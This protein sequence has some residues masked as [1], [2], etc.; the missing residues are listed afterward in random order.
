MSTFLI[1]RD[2]P[3]V[4]AVWSGVASWPVGGRCFEFK[5]YGYNQ[6]LIKLYPKCENDAAFEYLV[7]DDNK[8]V[9]FTSNVTD[10]YGY[11]AEF[12]DI[13]ILNGS[14][15][16]HSKGVFSPMFN[17]SSIKEI[18]IT[19]PQAGNYCL[20]IQSL[21]NTTHKY[22]DYKVKFSMFGAYADVAMKI[23]AAF[24]VTPLL[25]PVLLSVLLTLWFIN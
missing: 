3:N 20:W 5:D 2:Q 8:N 11:S 12:G 7:Y 15:Y 24:R 4:T 23:S 13:V 1:K 17:D 10:E 14:E 21:K 6:P 19:L 18:T 9:N 22:K 16:V 25:L